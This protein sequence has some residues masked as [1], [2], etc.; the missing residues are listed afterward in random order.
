MTT[1]LDSG[2]VTALASDRAKLAEIRRRGEW[3]P[4][5]PTA[6]LVES[7]TGDHRRDHATDRLLALCTIVDVDEPLARSAA[8][9]R[10]LAARRSISAV[11]AIVV[12]TA[13]EGGGAVVLTSAPSDLGRL[14]AHADTPVRVVAV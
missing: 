3:P 2:A 12:A 8:A 10:T 4:L 5:V 13:A 14:A 11:D 9:L 7:L 6:V 1:V